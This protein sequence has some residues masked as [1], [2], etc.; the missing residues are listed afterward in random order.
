M[1][2]ISFQHLLGRRVTQNARVLH[3]ELLFS[4]LDPVIL[5]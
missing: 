2:M 4:F 1:H 5:M 3:L